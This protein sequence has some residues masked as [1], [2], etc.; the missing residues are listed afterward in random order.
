M[1]GE[2]RISAL[3]CLALLVLATA[4]CL[5]AS[6]NSADLR[7]ESDL[8]PPGETW[9][10]TSDAASDG[11]DAG[12]E[13][14][15]QQL[16]SGAQIDA[17]PDIAGDLQS[18]E[19]DVPPVLVPA[20]YSR[21]DG[22][23][24]RITPSVLARLKAIAASAPGQDETH[25]IKVGD[26]ITDTST[27][28]YCFSGDYIDL[29]GRVE[30]QATIAFYDVGLGDGTTPFNRKGE[31]MLGGKTAAWV[32]GGNPSP[33]SKELDQMQ[34]RVA[35]VMFGTNDIGYYAF[36]EIHTTLN[37]FRKNYQQ[38]VEQLIA[39]GVVPILMAIPP[40]TKL[41]ER[42]S[43]VPALNAIVR[44]IAQSQQVPFV[45]YHLA[46]LPL[47]SNG[48]STDGIHPNAYYQNGTSRSC[49]FT[50]A[51]LQKGYTLRNLVSIEA[52]D[53]VRRALSG[54]TQVLAP[55]SDSPAK[56]TGTKA[57]PYV[58]NALPYTDSQDTALSGESHFSTYTGCNANQD[59][60][61]AEVVYRIELAQ[62]TKLRALIL[63]EDSVDID[64]H[65]L[66]ALDVTACLKRGHREVIADLAA[67]TYYLVMDTFVS[68]GQPL[69]GRYHLVVHTCLEG[70]SY[71]P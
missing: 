63:S 10:A 67:G 4:G 61:G 68:S 13:P 39:A 36:S 20:R 6:G 54:D 40:R 11:V 53:R 26:S 64:V 29:D 9:V 1:D 18:A 3:C 32:I 69:S 70:D 34:P 66:S 28:M 5:G 46:M 19:S 51:G 45:D 41:P 44:G 15:A 16:D 58:I 55:Q 8:S 62:P 27:F 48:L 42:N 50:A 33:L 65:L 12:T 35:I 56:G 38:L 7:D 60:S 2:R 57:D 30:L 21:N 31:A 24:S 49:V 14:D 59:E 17:A 22:V 37:W 71:C 43:Y 47:P 52:L 25:F 23:H